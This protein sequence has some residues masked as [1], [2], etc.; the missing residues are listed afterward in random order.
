MMCN[1]GI[2]SEWQSR[3]EDTAFFLSL[4]R[5]GDLVE[6]ERDGY[7][8]WAV[9]IG[10]HAMAEGTEEEDFVTVLPCV[11]HRANPTDNPDNLSGFFGSSRSVAKGAYGIGDVVVEPLKDVWK[12]SRARI[13]NSMDNATEPFPGQKVVERALGVVHGEEAQAFTAYN[14][15]TNNCEHFAHWCRHGL[16]ISCQVARKT[17]QFMKLGLVATAAILPR[18]IAMLGAAVVAGLQMLTEVRRAGSTQPDPN[19]S[20]DDLSDLA[21]VATRTRSQTESLARTRAQ[22]RALAMAASG[23][24]YLPDDQDPTS[25]LSEISDFSDLGANNQ[26]APTSPLSDFSDLGT[27][28]SY[29]SDLGTGST[30]NVRELEEDLVRRTIVLSDGEMD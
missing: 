11:V 3:G 13:N 1:V 24:S 14:V 27:S 17:E 6:F 10:E 8:H 15:M 26:E 9:F 7:Q 21:S 30:V 20:M 28:S 18:P 2:I 16:G 25:P 5:P 29:F 19:S 12:E 23:N 4:L 22:T